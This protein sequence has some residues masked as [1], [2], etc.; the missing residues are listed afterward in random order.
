MVG[1]FKRTLLEAMKSVRGVKIS[2]LELRFEKSVQISDVLEAPNGLGA[3]VG[4][5][6]A[7]YLRFYG[8]RGERSFLPFSR[9]P[10][11]I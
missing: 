8:S 6:E 2:G 1:D 3:V 5:D 4:M 11:T 10:T 9:T 7:Q